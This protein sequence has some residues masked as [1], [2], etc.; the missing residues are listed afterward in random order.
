MISDF[1]QINEHVEEM[2]QQLGGF[3]AHWL[4]LFEAENRSYL[5]VGIGRTGGRHR[6][7]YIVNHLVTTFR[8]PGRPV[9]W[10][11]RDVQRLSESIGGLAVP[12]NA[13][14]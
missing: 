9:Q 3:L 2:V 7:V 1:L 4:P 13:W 14:A 12:E 6:S 5:V 10:H 8:D 11:H